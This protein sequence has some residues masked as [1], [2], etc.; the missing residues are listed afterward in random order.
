MRTYIAIHQSWV[1]S[2][3]GTIAEIHPAAKAIGVY[4]DPQTPNLS[5]IDR[6]VLISDATVV[7]R[8]NLSEAVL[9]SV[10]TLPVLY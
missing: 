10:D 5:A 8:K 2:T 6:T 1:M 4:G 7:L 9:R 3:R